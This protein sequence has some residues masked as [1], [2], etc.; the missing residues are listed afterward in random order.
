MKDRCLGRV[1]AIPGCLFHVHGKPVYEITYKSRACI[2]VSIHSPGKV[3]ICYY[4]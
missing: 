3:Y 2:H 1:R 4:K